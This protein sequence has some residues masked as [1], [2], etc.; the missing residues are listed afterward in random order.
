PVLRESHLSA[1]PGRPAEAGMAFRW[2]EG[3]TAGQFAVGQSGTAEEQQVVDG[4]AGASACGAEPRIGKL[5]GRERIVGAGQAEIGLPAKDKVADLPVKSRLDA[6]GCSARPG[7]IVVDTAPFIAERRA[8][9]GSGPGE[10][11]GRGRRGVIAWRN[12]RGAR[13]ARYHKRQRNE[14]GK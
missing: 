2:S 1:E 7:R 12:I 13:G 8:E 11:I 4:E 6:A 3:G 5:P 14:R 9:I 10:G